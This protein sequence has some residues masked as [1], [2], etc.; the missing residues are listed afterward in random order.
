MQRL[1][2]V[3]TTW[4]S[5]LAYVVGIITTDGNLSPDGRHINITSKDE[6]MVQTVKKLLRLDNKIGKKARGYS[7]D[8]KYFVFQFGDI[9]FYEFLLSIGLMP[10]K[11]KILKAVDIPSL[12]FRDFLR[13]CIDGDGSISISRHPESR[14]PQLRVRLVSASLDFLVWIH[15]CIRNECRVEGG[16]IYH[17]Q[18]KSVYTLSFGK[19][20]SMKIIKSMYYKKSLPSLK[21][22]QSIVLKMGGW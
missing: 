5:E 8:K 16:Y 10:A 21:R 19:A 2:K 20:D 22:K 12:F 9:N 3:D 14:L 6:E 7:T 11:S 1:S 4:S 13:G 15:Q 17:A 18:R